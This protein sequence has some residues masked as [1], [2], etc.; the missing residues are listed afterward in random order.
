M[1]GYQKIFLKAFC[2]TVA[3]LAGTVVATIA[4][5]KG[6]TVYKKLKE[7]SEERKNGNNE[8]YETGTF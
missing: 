6:I 3:F 5:D 1:R 2:D 8:E 4:V 7:K